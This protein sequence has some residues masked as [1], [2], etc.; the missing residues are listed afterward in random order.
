MGEAKPY[1]DAPEALAVVAEADVAAY[2]LTSGSVD[3]G[4]ANC[5]RYSTVTVFARFRGW[6]TFRPRRRAIR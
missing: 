6:S 1:S 2:I 5:Y 4:R 3:S